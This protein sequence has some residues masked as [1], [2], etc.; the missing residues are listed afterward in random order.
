MA[1]RI[2]DEIVP[3]EMAIIPIIKQ[4]PDLAEELEEIVLASEINPLEAQNKIRETVKTYRMNVINGRLK[5][6]AMCS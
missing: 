1:S 5:P 2:P 3:L 4:Y 6:K